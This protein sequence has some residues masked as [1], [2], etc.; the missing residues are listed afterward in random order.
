MA[1]INFFTC[2]DKFGQNMM[3]LRGR[4]MMMSKFYCAYGTQGRRA[5]LMYGN[6]ILQGELAVEA[7]EEMFK[8]LKAK[9]PQAKAFFL[10]FEKT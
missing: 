1:C 2:A 5:D 8:F 4:R 6:G 7:T 3:Q 9:Y 10:Y